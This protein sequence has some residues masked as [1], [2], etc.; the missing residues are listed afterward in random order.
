MRA[1]LTILVFW[2]AGA[3][4]TDGVAAPEPAPLVDLR[5]R[6]DK[7]GLAPRRQGGRPTCSVFTMTTALEYAVAG[8]QGHCP[9][10]SV[11]FLNWASNKACGDTQDGGFFSDLWKGFAAYGICAEE[12]MPYAYARLYMNDA[13]WVDFQAP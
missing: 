13:A 5:P 3:A 8:R 2:L 4:W 6:F 9:R 10:L 12:E 1:G 7:L 11:E